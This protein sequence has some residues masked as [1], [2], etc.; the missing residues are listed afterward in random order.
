MGKRVGSK[1]P[2]RY[3]MS[4]GPFVAMGWWAEDRNSMWKYR[5][6]KM[7]EMGGTWGVARINN[8]FG[9]TNGTSKGSGIQATRL[10]RKAR[11]YLPDLMTKTPTGIRFKGFEPVL[12]RLYTIGSPADPYTREDSPVL[13]AAELALVQPGDVKA[14]VYERCDRP[15]S[16]LGQ[17]RRRYDLPP[18]GTW[19]KVELEVW[20]AHGPYAVLDSWSSHPDSSSA[21]GI[22]LGLAGGADGLGVGT[23]GADKMPLMRSATSP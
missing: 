4:C 8:K 15:W 23:T 6:A 21:F 5:L 17:L 11:A 7:A 9:L 14:W 16:T 12:N 19:Y 1:P 18:L 20:G 3:S 2:L 22:S 13:V 10:R